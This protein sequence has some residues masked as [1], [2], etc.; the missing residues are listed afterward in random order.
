[1]ANK[2][3][4]IDYLSKVGKTNKESWQ[5]LALMFEYADAEK[6]RK[7]WLKHRKSDN[8]YGLYNAG[9]DP[10]K[11]F[12]AP[13]TYSTGTM[14]IRDP[15]MYSTGNDSIIKG[16]KFEPSYTLPPSATEPHKGN[17]T[18]EDTIKIINDTMTPA[19]IEEMV[20][21]R[22]LLDNGKDAKFL[23]ELALFDVHIGK[24]AVQ[25]ESGEDYNIE[26]AVERYNKAVLDL[27]SRV[28]RNTIDRILLP[29]GNDFI[30][31]DS[32]RNTTTAG[33]PQDCSGRYTTM[34]TTA[35]KLLIDTINKLASIAPVDVVVIH[36]NHDTHTMFAIGE[37]ISAYYRS[38]NR[39]TVDNSPTQ[40]KY[41]AYHSTALQ[42][43]HGNE[44]KHNDLPL[45]FASEKP[46][47]WGLSKHRYCQLGHYHKSKKM[48]YVG[49]DSLNGV[50]IQIIPSLS[51][52]DA[53]HMSKGYISNKQAKAFLF[54]KENG[55]ISE[56]TYHG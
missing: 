53:W 42:F 23:L 27:I 46:Q 6:A 33:T 43:T 39:V 1:M 25:E 30:H 24:L 12:Y 22:K 11:I 20:T 13:P 15:H 44:E 49:V 18:L 55:L 14:G 48:S 16:N 9:V 40:R 3:G 37:V 10:Y 31:V 34:V 7:A 21:F 38:D 52:A 45:I 32:K 56:F 19:S 35:K 47:L 4:L 50:E 17:P 26:I 51:G 36:G 54:D 8:P 29:I 28:D 2:Q 5:E 41:Y